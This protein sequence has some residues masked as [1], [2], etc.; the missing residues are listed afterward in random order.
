MERLIIARHAHARS[1]HNGVV[2]C[3]P[4]GEGLSEQGR[5]EALSL[6]AAVA[7]E[8]IELGVA[9][10]LARTRETLEAALGDRDVPTLV[11]SQLD[12]IHFGE[13]EGGALADYRTWAWTT[14]PDALCPGG[15][16]SRVTAALRYA[17]ALELLLGREEGVVL[18]ISHALPIRYVVDAADGGFPA[19]RIGPV[20]HAMP[21]SLA[22]AAVELA[23]TTLRTWAREPRFVDVS[24][25]L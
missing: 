6:R 13:F 16:E 10:R 11:V 25:D 5:E 19:S 1:N 21:F 18:A 7:D 3:A 15:G 12:E 8:P 20:P 23:A 17:D 14:E 24:T 9:T 2:S 4:P 22:A